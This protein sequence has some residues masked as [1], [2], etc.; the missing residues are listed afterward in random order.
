LQCFT[1]FLRVQIAYRN[2]LTTHFGQSLR[3]RPFPRHF[4]QALAS[5]G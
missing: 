3:N 4:W 1:K 5:I 2:A